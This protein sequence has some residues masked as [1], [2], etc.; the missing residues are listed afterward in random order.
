[1]TAYKNILGAEALVNKYAEEFSVINNSIIEL[2]AKKAE[3]ESQLDSSRERFTV[4]SI[5]KNAAT[6]RDLNLIIEYLGEARGQKE[7]IINEISGKVFDDAVEVISNH[8]KKSVYEHNNINKAIAEHIY[9]IRA[10]YGELIR[11]ETAEQGKIAAFAE[12]LKPY[13]ESE[14]DFAAKNQGRSI[15]S[16]LKEVGLRAGKIF[17]VIPEQ[18]Y[19]VKGA[20]KADMSLSAIH[21][22]KTTELNQLYQ[23]DVENAKKQALKQVSR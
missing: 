20:L 18:S 14:E 4:E 12:D 13:F 9:Q 1:M 6:K 7:K 5:E 17:H 22:P 16:R 10:L 11:L 19:Y 21:L 2:E 3:L 23:V 8:A 15:L